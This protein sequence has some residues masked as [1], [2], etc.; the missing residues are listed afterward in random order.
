MTVMAGE[1]SSAIFLFGVGNKKLT[2]CI[3]SKSCGRTTYWDLDDRYDTGDISNL[4]QMVSMAD[5][6]YI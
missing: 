2:G 1:R 5:I 4:S 6:C 3:L